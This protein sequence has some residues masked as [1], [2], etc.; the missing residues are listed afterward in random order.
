MSSS[1]GGSGGSG[2]GMTTEQRAEQMAAAIKSMEGQLEMVIRNEEAA[3]RARASA[4]SA[5]ESVRQIKEKEAGGTSESS[6]ETLLAIGGGVFVQAKVAPS[7][8]MLL[9]IGSGVAVEK[10]PKLVLDYLENRIREIDVAIKN[11]GA[12]KAN[13]AEHIEQYRMQLSQVIQSTYGQRGHV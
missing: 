2:G 11:T 10:D 7:D 6:S 4:A 3:A 8:K 13:L 9:E 5:V 1:G 12:E